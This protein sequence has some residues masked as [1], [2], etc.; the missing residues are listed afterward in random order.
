MN[1][2]RAKMSNGIV[3]EYGASVALSRC[4]GVGPKNMRIAGQKV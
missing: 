3:I 1:E 2:I 4:F